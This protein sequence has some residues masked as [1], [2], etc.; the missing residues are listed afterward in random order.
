M[1]MQAGF[2]ALTSEAEEWEETAGI[3]TGAAETVKGLT[4]TTA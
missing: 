3:L 1:T 4:L 2:E